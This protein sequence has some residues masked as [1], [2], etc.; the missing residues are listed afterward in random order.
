[1]ELLLRAAGAGGQLIRADRLAPLGEDAARAVAFLL[2]FD[3]GRILVAADPAAARLVATAVPDRE[4]APTG[5]LDASEEEPWWRILGAPLAHAH[6]DA[7]QRRVAL[8]FQSSGGDLRTIVLA[9][10]GP[11]IHAALTPDA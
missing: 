8:Q 2:T 7:D 9:I 3:I 6:S 11:R 10:D 5:L 4:S 1:M